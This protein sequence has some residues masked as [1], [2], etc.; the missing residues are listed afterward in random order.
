MKL[1][2]GYWLGVM[3]IALAIASLVL[4]VVMCYTLI[5]L[6]LV[7]GILFSFVAG[8][9]VLAMLTYWWEEM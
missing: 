8:T 4:L 3:L 9:G 5:T 2:F 6:N 7:L 1:F